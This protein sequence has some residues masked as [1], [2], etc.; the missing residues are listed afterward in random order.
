MIRAKKSSGKSCVLSP[1]EMNSH[2]FA[3]CIQKLEDLR[4]PWNPVV[5]AAIDLLKY[6]DA[7]AYIDVAVEQFSYAQTIHTEGRWKSDKLTDHGKRNAAG[8]VLSGRAEVVSID[9]RSILDGP[10]PFSPVRPRHLAAMDPGSVLG[11]YEFTA[12]LFQAPEIHSYQVLSGPVCLQFFHSKFNVFRQNIIPRD[13]ALIK[14]AAHEKEFEDWLRTGDNYHLILAFSSDPSIKMCHAELAFI[15]LKR[16]VIGS[17]ESFR[18]SWEAFR[19]ALVET[20]WLQSYS[21]RVRDF[22]DPNLENYRFVL[23]EHLKLIDLE[24]YKKAFSHLHEVIHGSGYLWAEVEDLKSFPAI[25]DATAKFSLLPRPLAGA[26]VYVKESLLQSPHGG[27][28]SVIDSILRFRSKG[29]K[30]KWEDPLQES[31][32][33]NATKVTAAE[34]IAKNFTKHVASDFQ[35]NAGTANPP[36]ISTAKPKVMSMARVK[37]FGPNESENPFC[38][39]GVEVHSGLD[40]LPAIKWIEDEMGSVPDLNGTLIV[41]CQHFLR[42]TCAWFAHLMSKGAKIIAIGKDY[43][44]CPDIA[45]RIQRIGVTVVETPTWEWKPGEYA[46]HL[47]AKAKLGWTE[48]SNLIATGNYKEVIVIDDGGALHRTSGDFINKTKVPKWCGVEQTTSGEVHARMAPYPVALVSSHNEKRKWESRIIADKIF[49]NSLRLCA[50]LSGTNKRIG[51][52]GAGAI[53]KAVAERFSKD[54]YSVFWFSTKDSLT[55]DS[56]NKQQTL[57]EL[58]T[59]ADVIFGCAGYDVLNALLGKEDGQSMVGGKWFISCS[60]MDVEF[61]SL[62]KLSNRA[63]ALCTPLRLHNPFSTMAVQTKPAPCLV[64]N[65][66]FPINFDRERDSVPLHLI[67]FTRALMHLGLMKAREITETGVVDEPSLEG[68]RTKL[69]GKLIDD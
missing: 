30:N 49:E 50:P 45:R 3:E 10:G 60:S 18:H 16:P 38:R 68:L 66:G 23:D 54:G 27:L 46:V 35:P 62:L 20:A 63:T 32:S 37:V 17:L 69:K 5:R 58:I 28:V 8:I 24:S 67:Q 25:A 14:H 12:N 57:E 64:L 22:R 26:K 51:I 40:T 61:S 13:N 1:G 39:L 59:Q 52:I 55:G 42:E 11:A 33:R 36:L 41:A 34:A 44:T 9:N 6:P 56:I 48:A 7:P 15:D 53:A 43:S 65:G 47:E 21:S 19:N 31:I 4:Q 29:T 2:P